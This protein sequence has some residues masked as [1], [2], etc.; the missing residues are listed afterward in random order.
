MKKFLIGLLAGI[1]L[2]ILT[3]F[4]VFFAI[5][6]AGERRPVVA[7]ASTL[8]LN[9]EGPIPEQ[10]PITVPLPFFQAREPMTV[11]DVWEVLRRAS[12]DPRIKAAVLAPQDV[13]AGW[14]KLQEI[15]DG[16]LKFKESG[17]PL[18]AFLRRPGSREYYLATAADQVYMSTEDVLNVKGIRAELIFLKN[19]LDKIGVE[20][21]I[22]H[23]GKYKDAGDMFTRGSMSPETREVLNSVLD[24]LFGG[25]IKSVAEGRRM[26][27]Q[28][29]K[30]LI[31][32]GPFLASKAKQDGL[33][34]DLT[35][36]DQVYEH[37]KTRLNQSEIRKIS[38]RD[39]LRA[40]ISGFDSGPRIALLVGE[41][42]IM[43]GEESGFGDEGV[44]YSRSFISTVRRVAADG[45]IR[46]VVL[47]VNSPGGDALASDEMLH[48]IKQL[49]GKKPLVIS[50]SDL[51]ASGGYY[52][53][54]SGDRVLAYPDT[55]TGSIGVIYG[56]ANLRGLYDKLGVQKEYLTRGRFAD[57]DSDYKPLS[58]AGRAK[59]REGVDE[60][61]R[62]FLR[63]VAEGR[64]R[65]VEEVRPLAEG[66]V[67]TGEQARANGLI[68]ELGG[69]DRAV[70]LVKE[71]AGIAP[72][73]QVRLVTYPPK[74]SLL[75]YFMEQRPEVS[76]LA[77]FR[78]LI[79]GVDPR[80]LIRGGMLRL[81]PYTI[82]VE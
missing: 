38:Y 33:V 66:R 40:P 81:A 11:R 20:M 75:S 8:V 1:L 23:A 47:R 60:V 77:R 18:V 67:W 30:A 52:I 50:M 78:E 65:Q 71:K 53:A 63:V 3:I 14:G 70:E 62:G 22:E 72:D 39:Y 43:S 55:F 61:Y 54:M 12:V 13:G 76:A 59:L 5:F 24:Q 82:H 17:K 15:R 57:I 64:R 2:T 36:E 34:D 51:A 9:L 29:V 44:L 10:P 41:G 69:L 25:F 68:D 46:G 16:L 80:V 32:Q 7:D 31:D 21:E 28:K 45:G 49:A 58:E 26:D 27:D 6:K 42:A 56:K 35:F 4:V 19:T 73:V 74:R 48:E 37:L 79:N